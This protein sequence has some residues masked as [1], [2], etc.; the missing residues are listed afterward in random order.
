MPVKIKKRELWRALREHCL[1]CAGFS[2]KDVRLCPAAGCWLWPYRMGYAHV[3]E[4]IPLAKPHACD[5]P[6][7]HVDRKPPKEK[8]EPKTNPRGPWRGPKRPAV[9]K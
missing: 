6:R 4:L 9:D 5:D 8:K 1:E 2:R 7:N 3:A